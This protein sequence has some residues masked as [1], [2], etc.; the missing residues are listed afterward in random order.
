MEPVERREARNQYMRHTQLRFLEPG[1]E[2]ELRIEKVN[3]ET[4]T[5]EVRCFQPL[6]KEK[7]GLALVHPLTQRGH[8]QSRSET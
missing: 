4:E 8:P 3:P 1:V 6:K 7:T 5:V 2:L